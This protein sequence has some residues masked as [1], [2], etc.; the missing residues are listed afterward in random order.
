MLPIIGFGCLGASLF[1]CIYFVYA[2]VSKKVY[3]AGRWLYRC[4]DTAAYWIALVGVVVMMV[5]TFFC[6]GIYLPGLF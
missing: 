4:E 5:F 1:F 2:L 3:A 6:A